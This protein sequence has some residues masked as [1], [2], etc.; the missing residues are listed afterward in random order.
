MDDLQCFVRGF[1]TN[2]V[3]GVQKLAKVGNLSIVM[4]SV[5]CKV[6]WNILCEKQNGGDHPSRI[7]PW[8]RIKTLFIQNKA[9]A[10]SFWEYFR[11]KNPS[12]FLHV[13][14]VWKIIRG[15]LENHYF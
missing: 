11:M 3:A 7:L 1:H 2:D 13:C 14:A 4:R 8:P 6:R 9:N 12:Q 15:F 5:L 10:F